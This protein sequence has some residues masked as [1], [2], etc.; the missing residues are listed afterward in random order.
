M[1][2]R[3]DDS[4]SETHS[5]AQKKLTPAMQQYHHFKAAHP[6]ALLLFQM[7]DFYETFHSDAEELAR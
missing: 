6:N 4:S 2:S 1:A 5:A 7:G 3:D